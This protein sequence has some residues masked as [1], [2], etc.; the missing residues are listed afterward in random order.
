MSRLKQLTILLGDLVALYLGLYLAIYLRYFTTPNTNQIAGFLQP[1]TLLFLLATI[2]IFISGLYDLRKTKNNRVLFQKILYS[3]FIWTLLGIIFFY[4]APNNNI[5][6]KTI[7]VL[8][9]ITGFGLIAMWRF[10]YNRFVALN[11][12]KT[13]IAFVGSSKE[14]QQIRELLKNS[15]QIGYE[16][17][18]NLE[19]ADL[20]VLDFNYQK[21]EI[22]TQELYRKIFQQT[23]IVELAD[24]YEIIYGRLPPFTFSESWFLT[25]FQEQSKKIY[26]RF[27]LLTDYA[28]AL[29][30][31]VFFIITYPIIAILI[32]LNS[33]GPI[34]FKQARVGR[35]GKIFFIYK[36]R[37]MKALHSDGS[38]ETKGAQYATVKD[39][40]ITAV[41][42]FLRATRLD[43]IPQFINIL[44]NEMALIGP[45]PERPEFVEQLT[46]MMPFYTLRHLVKPGLT[47]W[48]Q[49]QR[50]YYGTLDENLS[51]LEYDLFYI[52]N[53][54]PLLDLAIVLKT[55]NVVLGMKGR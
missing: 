40:R 43:E 51:K 24:F 14:T 23:S 5:S 53:R 36:Y 34:L 44:K 10:F 27:R 15:P 35:N 42:K 3:A 16:V 1:F 50:S 20:I 52:K 47:G 21:N 32:K 29:I 18:E 19:N 38:A 9:T 37:T 8:T 39:S 54:G 41:G 12:L 11:I 49:L 26:D 55:I 4:I 17:V 25:K 30:M 22:L 13:K 45:R 48:A 46:T 28:S 7:L 6:P 31:A 33:R 2:I